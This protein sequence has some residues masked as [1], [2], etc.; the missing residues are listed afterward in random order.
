MT[1]ASLWAG[2]AER[3]RA[4]RARTASAVNLGGAV[5]FVVAS[6]APIAGVRRLIGFDTSAFEFTIGGLMVV[7]LTARLVTLR[8]LAGT[9][10]PSLRRLGYV[11]GSVFLNRLCL[12]G[13]VGSGLVA[14]ALAWF[15]LCSMS[16]SH[17]DADLLGVTGIGIAL[18]WPLIVLTMTLG[19]TAC[20]VIAAQIR[21][22]GVS[23]EREN[24]T[25]T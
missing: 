5:A 22:T 16:M 9:V 23:A 3:S 14:F 8:C 11:R 10:V 1:T 18:G 7:S 25:S 24:T 2:R 19:G 4:E 15:G 17:I 21:G 13:S 20:L 12:F 6:A